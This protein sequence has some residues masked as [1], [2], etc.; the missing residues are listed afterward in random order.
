MY[1]KYYR[2]GRRLVGQERD[3]EEEKKAQALLTSLYM[4]ADLALSHCFL[5]H[6]LNTASD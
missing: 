4:L 1:K 6:L 3:K 2:K 5:R